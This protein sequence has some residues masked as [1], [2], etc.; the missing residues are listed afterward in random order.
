M[1]YN[2]LIVDD[3]PMIIAGYKAALY[4]IADDNDSIVTIIKIKIE[5]LELIKVAVAVA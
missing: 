3:H 4:S 1:T 5:G 2:T